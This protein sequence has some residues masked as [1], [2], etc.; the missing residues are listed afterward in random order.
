MN[1]TFVFGDDDNAVIEEASKALW[2]TRKDI[3][4]STRYEV[5]L[6]NSF[7][8]RDSIKPYFNKIS[9]D[10]DEITTEF[11]NVKSCTDF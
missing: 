5:D 1:K 2:N 11:N 10:S 9:L 6:M 4:D 7:S 8:G 3:L